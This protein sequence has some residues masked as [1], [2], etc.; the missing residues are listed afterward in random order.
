M[1]ST[2][3]GGPITDPN[4][5][6]EGMLLPIGGYKGSGLAIVL[7]LLAGPLNGA[8]FG[9]DVIDF[10]ADDASECNTGH[11]IIALDVARFTPLAE[12]RGRGRSSSARPAGLAPASGLRCHPHAGRAAPPAPRGAFAR[13]RADATGTDRSAR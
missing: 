9:R 10:N 13:R 1:V 6:A 4:L 3:D 5:S 8:A 11:F 2:K 12:F 7:G